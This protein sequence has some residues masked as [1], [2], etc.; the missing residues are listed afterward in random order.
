MSA[1]AITTTTF[2]LVHGT[3]HGGW[4]WRFIAPKLQAAGHNVYTPTLTGLGTRSHL[5]HELNRVSLDTYVKDITNI[6]FYE[7]LL[8]VIL[9]GHVMEAW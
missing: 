5:L 4:C 7:D 2:V 1:G 8:D 9:V 3:G 6:I